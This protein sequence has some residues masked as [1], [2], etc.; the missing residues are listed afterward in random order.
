MIAPAMNSG[1]A[2][3]LAFRDLA[4]QQ[5][6]VKRRLNLEELP[7]LAA[8]TRSG[9]GCELD[10]ELRF[11]KDD[12]GEIWVDGL[13]QTL[14]ALGCARCA[15]VFERSLDV[16]FALCIVAEETHA[17]ELSR[18]RDV[19]LARKSELSIAEIIEDE[20]I[21]DLPELLC[22]ESPC[23]WLPR[24]SYPAAEVAAAELASEAEADNPF[25]VLEALKAGL[26][27]GSTPKQGARESESSD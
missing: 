5:A 23:P 16:E 10:V 8:L 15:E 14:L 12:Q 21:L 11:R 17:D 24:M 27:D 2:Q 3:E 9:A 26:V 6:R 4:G 20:L 19:L 7:R 22:R 18:S 13:V 25:T 1:P